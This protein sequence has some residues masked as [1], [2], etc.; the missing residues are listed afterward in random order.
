MNI[1]SV[2]LRCLT[3]LGPWSNQQSRAEHRN[4]QGGSSRLWFRH[5]C[6]RTFCEWSEK[7]HYF[8]FFMHSKELPS[9]LW[10]QWQLWMEKKSSITLYTL[11]NDWFVAECKPIWNNTHATRRESLSFDLSLFLPGPLLHSYEIPIVQV[12]PHSYFVISPIK[13]K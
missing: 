2:N 6:W 11:D 8:F 7:R 13:M 12:K 10:K 3:M 9:H 5:S 4:A 1:L